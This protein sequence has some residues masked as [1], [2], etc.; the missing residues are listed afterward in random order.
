MPLTGLPPPVAR[1]MRLSV[2]EGVAYALMVGL[3]E[4][5][6]VT[7][8]LRLQ[9]SPLQAALVVS[10]PLFVGALGPLAAVRMLAH[11]R[12]RRGLAVL[13]AACQAL[14]LLALAL[15]DA[16]DFSTPEIVI[17]VACLHQAFG[18]ATGTAWSSWFGDLVP[19]AVRG[20]YFAMRT[21]WVQ[22]A[23]C[24]GL[25]GAGLLLQWLEPA[26]PEEAAGAGGTGFTLILA[27]AALCRAVSAVLLA[28]SHEN[29]F[30]GL[31]RGHRLRRFLAT[32][33]GRAAWR[34]VATGALFQLVV[35]VS[36][37]YFSPYMLTELG[38]DYVEFMTATVSIVLWKVAMLPAWGRVI[39]HHGARSTYA[40][41]AVLAA[42]VPLPWLWAKGVVWVLVAQSFSGFAWAGY[43]VSYFTLLL[44]SSYVRTRAQLFAAQSLA[45]GSGQ[46]LGTLAGGWMLGFSRGF[47]LVFALSLAGRMALA[48][49]VPGLVP[50]VRHGPHLGRRDVFLRVIGLRPHGGLAYRPMPDGLSSL[51]PERGTEETS[52]EDPTANGEDAGCP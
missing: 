51:S 13:T 24:V 5:Y 18:Q 43:E 7:D 15:S 34:L 37:P 52:R 35:Y 3:G 39:D 45:N 47:L 42:L 6:F 46:L 38:F 30:H 28:L 44:E 23:T 49:F 41:A 40:L 2:W 11:L 32:D 20:R 14:G 8:A 4:T 1:A 50:A 25:V 27:L 26:R 10:L 17:A 19:A 31:S 21:L 36:S 9:A 33:R 48:L 22:F 29:R 12:H 16:L